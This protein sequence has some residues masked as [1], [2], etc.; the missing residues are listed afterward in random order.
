MLTYMFS[1]LFLLVTLI[2]LSIVNKFKKNDD[3][4]NRK[5]LES[6]KM[7]NSFLCEIQKRYGKEDDN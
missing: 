3:V 6:C 5:N 4:D 2:L 1:F 7:C